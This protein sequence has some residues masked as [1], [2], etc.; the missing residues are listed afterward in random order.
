MCERFGLMDTTNSLS[1]LVSCWNLMRIG[2]WTPQTL[3]HILFHAEILQELLM[4]TTGLWTPW[5][6]GHHGLMDTTNSLAHLVSCWNLA[7]IAYGHHGL[8]DTTNSLAHLVSC[9]NL[10][11]ICLWTPQILS[12]ILFL[13]EILWDFT[14]RH[15]IVVSVNSDH[16]IVVS[17]SLNSHKISFYVMWLTY[18]PIR[19]L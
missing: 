6:Y 3:S 1:L 2:F 15:H 19:M 4:D 16:D 11:R 5:A 8:M 17:I 9:W 12:H 7:R 14:K 13:A 18:Q 10:M